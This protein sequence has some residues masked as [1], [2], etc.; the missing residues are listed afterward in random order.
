M[1]PAA[2]VVGQAAIRRHAR[3]VGRAARPRLLEIAHS[4][5]G[6]LRLL[7][8]PISLFCLNIRASPLRA[9]SGFAARP[10]AGARM[11]VSSA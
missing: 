11:R 6:G 9:H 8:E 3:K 1:N 4:S 5:R 7:A 10:L 2:V